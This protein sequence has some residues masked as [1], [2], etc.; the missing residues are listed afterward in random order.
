MRIGAL[1][2]G[3]S[4][5][6]D[7]LRLLQTCLPQD[8]IVEV[9]A[10]DLIHDYDVPAGMTD[11]TDVLTTRLYDGSTATLDRAFLTPLLQNAIT[12]LE[13]N[14]TDAIILLS[15]GDFPSLRSAVPLIKPFAATCQHLRGM[16][17]RRIGVAVPVPEQ[18]DTSRLKWAAYGFDATVWVMP[19]GLP[20]AEIG[21]WLRL[22]ADSGVSVDA[23][24]ID[25][26]RYAPADLTNLHGSGPA[27][28]DVGAVGLSA[29]QHIITPV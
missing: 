5:R 10:L 18:E 23:V 25:D 28:L 13:Q 20:A 1:T 21:G 15:A 26:V 3:H 27:M 14:H 12:Q 11:P 9:G 16:R 7:L 19:A 4:P 29:V 22:Q 2:I 17:A 8:H 6:H 24:V